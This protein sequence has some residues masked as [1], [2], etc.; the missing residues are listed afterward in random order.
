V[1]TAVR[2]GTKWNLELDRMN[3]DTSEIAREFFLQWRARKVP[4]T[5]SADEKPARTNVTFSPVEARER[6][7]CESVLALLPS[8]RRNC[9]EHAAADQKK[10]Y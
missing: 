1:L 10:F 7:K 6:Q 3:G 2:L 5:V 9:G 8:C 4:L